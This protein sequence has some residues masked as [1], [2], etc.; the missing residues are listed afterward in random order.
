MT[1]EELMSLW[2]MF[3]MSGYEGAVTKFCYY[4]KYTRQVVMNTLDEMIDSGYVF[5]SWK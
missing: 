4:T 2:N 5:N 3:L 1:A